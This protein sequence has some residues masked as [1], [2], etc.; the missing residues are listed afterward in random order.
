MLFDKYISAW[1]NKEVGEYLALHHEDYEIVY[2]STNT[3]TKIN[4]L[5]LD[6]WA[7]LMVAA[8]FD[9]RRCLYEN[10]EIL[11]EHRIVTYGSGDR[12]ALMLVH[13]KKDGLLWRTES[14]A[15][16]LPRKD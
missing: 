7:N 16:P 14:G 4:D 12:E 11:V 2:H 1:D 6:Q 8:K 10:E 3:V 15:T 13:I 5:D 9:G